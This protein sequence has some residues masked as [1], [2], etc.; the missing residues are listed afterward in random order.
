MK[1]LTKNKF[2]IIV[3]KMDRLIQQLLDHSLTKINT[4][5]INDGTPQKNIDPAFFSTASIQ[6]S[7]CMKQ[8]INI[9]PLLL[10]SQEYVNLCEL[11]VAAN[12]MANYLNNGRSPR[13]ILRQV[14]NAKFLIKQFEP[15]LIQGRNFA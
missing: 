9:Q 13:W 8:L 10:C 5:G 7:S 1:N 11:I 4:E 6:L 15:L 14:D 2:E 3:I 12:E